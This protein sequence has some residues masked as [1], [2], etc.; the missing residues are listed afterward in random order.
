MLSASIAR[1]VAKRS[2]PTALAFLLVSGV[3]ASDY[4]PGKIGQ[5]YRTT[6]SGRQLEDARILHDCET[7]S[8]LDTRFFCHASLER[9]GGIVAT[10]HHG[11]PLPDA[12]VGLPPTRTVFTLAPSN[13]PAFT[14]LVVA[15][16]IDANRRPFEARPPPQV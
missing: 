4:V 12:P 14:G 5:R 9:L 2:G 15:H 8:S 3:L 1:I 6:R 7:P 13:S 10:L 16:V 11:Q